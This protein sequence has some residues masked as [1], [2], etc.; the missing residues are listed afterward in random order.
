M[1]VSLSLSPLVNPLWI[2]VRLSRMFSYCS[3]ILSQ[4]RRH[5]DTVKP[6]PLVSHSSK[7]FP[8]TSTSQ[9]TDAL[10]CFPAAS[11]GSEH[12]SAY[13]GSQSSAGADKQSSAELS[14]MSL[15]PSVPLS[16][17]FAT[18]SFHQHPTQSKPQANDSKWARFLPSVCVE[19]DE[20]EVPLQNAGSRMSSGG[21][22]G[23]LGA[24]VFSVEKCRAGNVYE[25]PSSPN[26]TSRPVGS[27]KPLPTAKRP[28][29]AL[30]FNT[31]FHTNEDF[32]DTY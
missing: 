20:D 10:C 28:C 9:R 5:G 27:H 17:F 29:P 30:S 32:D 3:F 2:K 23:A 19:D 11:L 15:K 26:I 31:L 16:S 14:T 4:P 24:K 18:S 12:I 8:R 13:N 22:E 6:S 21:S 7:G 25:L 1:F